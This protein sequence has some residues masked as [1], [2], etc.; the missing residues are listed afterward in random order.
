MAKVM[1]C[2]SSDYVNVYDK[3]DFVDVLVPSLLPLSQSK[4]EIILS[5]TDVIKWV[6]ERK[7]QAIPEVRESKQQSSPLLLWL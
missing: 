6:L 3:G 7:I 5:G 4:R 2:H 1:G